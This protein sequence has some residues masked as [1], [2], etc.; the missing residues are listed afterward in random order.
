MVE[1]AMKGV[2]DHVYRRERY[3]SAHIF[4]KDDEVGVVGVAGLTKERPVRS[5]MS[6]TSTTDS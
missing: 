3:V 6:V 2:W 5:M 4:V 1:D